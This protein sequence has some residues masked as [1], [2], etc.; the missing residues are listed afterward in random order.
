M[1]ATQEAE[2]PPKRLAAMI[3]GKNAMVAKLAPPAGGRGAK[4]NP[5]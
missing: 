2:L 5:Q 3:A 1:A 4:P